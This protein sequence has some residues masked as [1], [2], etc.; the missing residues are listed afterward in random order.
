IFNQFGKE[1]GKFENQNKI[2]TT[3]IPPG[4][5]FIHVKYASGK[6]NIIKAIKYIK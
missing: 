2:N 1:I 3:N 5:Y 6:N 4:I